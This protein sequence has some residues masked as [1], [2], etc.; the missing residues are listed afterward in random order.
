[1]T[2]HY[3]TCITCRHFNFESGDIETGAGWTFNCLHDHLQKYPD[4]LQKEDP[5]VGQIGLEVLRVLSAANECPDYSERHDDPN[6]Q[7]PYVEGFKE[8]RVK[9][10]KPMKRGDLTSWRLSRTPP[11]TERVKIVTRK[12]DD[13]KNNNRRRA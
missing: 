3:V 7:N 8:G 5:Y 12:N 2:D 13:G 6:W 1:M 11:K 4:D 9:K 10:H